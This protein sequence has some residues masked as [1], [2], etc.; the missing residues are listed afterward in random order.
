[1]SSTDLQGLEA[2][3]RHSRQLILV[4]ICISTP[5]ERGKKGVTKVVLLI[6]FHTE[7][8]F[9]VTAVKLSMVLVSNGNE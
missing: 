9:K 4:A 5:N 1:M 2:P 6:M 3:N 7:L 8:N